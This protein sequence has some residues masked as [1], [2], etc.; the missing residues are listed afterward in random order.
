VPTLV[1]GALVAQAGLAAPAHAAGV[2]YAAPAGS[3]TACTS[4]APCS[5]ATAVN[6]ATSS[7]EVV[8]ASGTYEMGTTALVNAQAGLNVHGVVG[9]PRPTI[10]TSASTGLEL[11][12][13]GVKVADLS[14]NHT[15]ALFG[16]NVFTTGISVQRVAVSSTAPVACFLGYSGLARDSL[17][18]TNAAG[19]VAVDD[20][21]GSSGSVT[22]GALTLRNL[23]AIATGPGSFGLRAGAGDFANIDVDVRN[24]IASGTQ[25]DVRAYRG[26]T[27]SDSDV[28][29]QNSNFDLVSTTGTGVTVSAA[30]SATNQTAA[31][32]WADAGFHQALGSPT[33]DRGAT[34]ASVGTTDI[35]GGARKVGLATD[36]GA[37]EF[38]PDTTPPDAVFDRTVKRKTHKHRAL[39]VFHASEPSTFSCVLDKRPVAPCSSPFKVKVKKR[40]RHTLQVFATDAV[41]LVDPTPATWTWKVRKKKRHRHHGAHHHG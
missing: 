16:L 18:A 24:V 2:R 13:T 14:I 41:G 22:N 37:D 26:T 17:C 35:D 4:V 31:P 9:Q 30:A 12:G 29:L 28:V 23:T 7:T 3:G 27:S 39:F 15:G 36:I 11:K 25:A 10:N 8:V 19:G 33:I 40:G 34:D 5:L 21:W 32:V 6:T 1:I 20:S 38:V